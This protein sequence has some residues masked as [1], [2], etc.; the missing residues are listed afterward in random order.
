MSALQFSASTSKSEVFKRVE[1]HLS[2]LNLTIS[3]H[4]MER[5]WGGFFV[6]N[7]T[8]IGKFRDLFFSEVQLSEDQLKLRL[9]PKILIVAPSQRLSW[10]Y[11]HR[12]AEVWKLISGE[13]KIVR[14]STDE[15]EPATEMKIGEVVSLKQGE[16]HR[17][18]GA[19]N[20]G[21]VAEIWIHTNPNE[22][23]DEEDIVRVEDDYSRK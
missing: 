2:S 7:E 21:I 10:Q 4:D 6:L 12:R 15:L 9:S 1:E 20:W 3:N 17:L 5:P 8:G 18:V 14:S 13:S 23:S 19:E 16:R 11:H 22:P